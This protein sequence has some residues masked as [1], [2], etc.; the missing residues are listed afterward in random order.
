MR[1]RFWLVVVVLLVL[2]AAGFASV[3]SR[4][5]ADHRG[6]R[7][8]GKAQ[9]FADRLYGDVRDMTMSLAESL[10]ITRR[11]DEPDKQ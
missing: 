7:L 11:A 1:E 5:V 4:G 3:G 9:E 2:V 8:Y 10:N 6:A